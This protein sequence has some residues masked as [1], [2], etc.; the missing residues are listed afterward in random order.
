M[1]SACAAAGRLLAQAYAGN[2]VAIVLGHAV[3]R[4][5]YAQ[6]GLM[7]NTSVSVAASG[8]VA[9]APAV[10]ALAVDGLTALAVRG[11]F[12]SFRPVFLRL[13]CGRHFAGL[14]QPL[15]LPD[16]Q[17]NQSWQASAGECRSRPGVCTGGRGGAA[18]LPRSRPNY[19]KLSISRRGRC[20][21]GPGYLWRLPMRRRARRPLDRRAGRE[22]VM[23]ETCCPASPIEEEYVEFV[24]R[25]PEQ[26]QAAYWTIP[27][28]AGLRALLC[29]GTGAGDAC[30][31]PA[32][33]AEH[34]GVTDRWLGPFSGWRC[35]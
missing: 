26:G 10:S 12:A 3:G 14:R 7:R 1:S 2:I 34:D 11:L 25:S 24:A 9:M 31:M 32:C 30:G 13:R 5:K 4:L 18:F 23:P 29:E 19:A 20:I 16:S 33:I 22:S 15:T 28:D 17:A 21:G 35:L 27:P 8:G 6:A